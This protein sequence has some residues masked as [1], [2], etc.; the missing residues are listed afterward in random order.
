MAVHD[1]EGTVRRAVESLLNQTLKNFELVVVDIASADS[2]P[3]ILDTMSERDIRINV[4][5]TGKCSRTQA[6]D[7]ALD[8]ALGSYVFVMDA[9]CWV[10]SAML[11]ELV[12]TAEDELLDLVVGGFSLSL[13]VEGSREMNVTMSAPS[14]SFPTQ[15]DF[16][17]SAWQ[18]FGSGQLLPSCGKLFSAQRIRD[19]GVHF[20]SSSCSDHSFVTS[21]LRDVERVGV[22]EGAGFHVMRSLPA[23][24]LAGSG[25]VRYLRLE[26]ESADLLDLYRH[27]DLDGDV[28]SVEM[29]QRRYINQLVECIESVCSK[30]SSVPVDARREMVAEMIGTDRAQ[31]AASVSHPHG[32]AETAMLGSIRSQNV[33]MVCA[34]ARITSSLHRGGLSG[35]S[36]DAF[37]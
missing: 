8:R 21:Y 13:S 32:I 20:E 5:H 33:G 4:L 35:V 16:R 19:W 24:A 2:T 15:H 1:A 6:L 30:E 27:W 14:V 26:Q 17:S 34:Q 11:E 31:L 29:L 37:V 28:A 9:D 3:R 10:E 25:P 7:L 36:P 22:V 12:D 18:L 23:A